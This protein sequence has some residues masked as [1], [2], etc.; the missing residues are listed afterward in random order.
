VEV[1]ERSVQRKKEVGK[2]SSHQEMTKAIRSENV[3]MSNEKNGEKPF[4][5]KPKGSN[6]KRNSSWVIAYVM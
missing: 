2:I 3:D 4:G 5:R 6:K 1:V